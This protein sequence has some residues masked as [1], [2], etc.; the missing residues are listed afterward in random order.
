MLC[1]WYIF[2]IWPVLVSPVDIAVYPIVGGRQRQNIKPFWHVSV[3][4]IVLILLYAVLELPV[5]TPAT[6]IRHGN[7]QGTKI[8]KL[9]GGEDKIYTFVSRE[10]KRFKPTK[11]SNKCVAVYV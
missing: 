5:A 1:K 10:N 7:P 6:Q 9:G 2:V 11:Q 4:R 3:L 8:R